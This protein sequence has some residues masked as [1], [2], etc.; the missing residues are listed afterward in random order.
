MAR[1]LDHSRWG[2]QLKDNWKKVISKNIM[3]AGSRHEMI[4]SLPDFKAISCIL[5]SHQWGSAINQRDADRLESA[6][7]NIFEEAD[8][9]T[10]MKRACC[11]GMFVS[12]G[13]ASLV[14]GGHSETGMRLFQRLVTESSHRASLADSCRET[15]DLL[16]RVFDGPDW[17]ALT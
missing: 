6:L 3:P 8:S 10:E 13:I 7:L 15:L 2:L 9:Q 16:E 12:V 4:K 17:S 1:N 14:C 5:A 11:Q